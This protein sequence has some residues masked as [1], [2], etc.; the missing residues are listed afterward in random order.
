MAAPRPSRY[1]FAAMTDVPK[2]D[3]H[4]LLEPSDDFAR[5]HLGPDQHDVTVMLAEIGAGSLDELIEQTIPAEIRNREPLR[6]SG[7]PTPLGESAALERLRAHASRNRVLRSC[8]GMGYSDTLVPPVIQRN[9]LENPG[10]YTQYTPYQA[11][12]SQGRL[13]ALLNFQTMVADL[14]ALPLANASLLDEATAAAEAMA[15]CFGVARQQRR[16]FFVSEDCHPQTIGVVRTRAE[17]MGLRLHVGPLESADPAAMDLCGVLAQYPTTDGRLFDPR[18]LIERVQRGGALAVVAADLLALTLIAPPGELG[19]DVA[20]GSTQRFGVPLG[21]GGPHA[22]YF[23]TRE[24]HARRMP[25]RLV[26]VSR[27]IHGKPA[28]RLAIQTREQHIRRDKATSNICTAQVL[29]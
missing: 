22:A 8:I 15:L 7:L 12:I 3:V 4:E 19:A 11:E 10:W 23:A 17:S 21:A 1:P 28:Y 27:D 2:G 18:A 24:I 26:G 5:R 20:V 14:T 25:G 29:L 13:E 16:G 6:L 9:V